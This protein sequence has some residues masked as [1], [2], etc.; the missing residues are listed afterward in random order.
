MRCPRPSNSFDFADL[1]FL[2]GGDSTARA[3]QEHGYALLELVKASD[4][5]EW[6]AD[7]TPWRPLIN[8]FNADVKEVVDEM[9]RT[10]QAQTESNKESNK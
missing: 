3:S 8:M 6:P 10:K 9:M 5:I 7:S 2:L 1:S 4:S